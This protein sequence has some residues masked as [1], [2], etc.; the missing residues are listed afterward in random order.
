VRA[1]KSRIQTSLIKST[2][3][4]DTQGSESRAWFLRVAQEKGIEAALA[5]VTSSVKQDKKS[6]RGI[7]DIEI[8][9]VS[10]INNGKEQEDM[11]DKTCYLN[12]FLFVC[13]KFLFL[14]S[15]EKHKNLLQRLFKVST[16]KPCLIWP[17]HRLV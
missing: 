14:F 6:K 2:P 16:Q 12:L 8:H 17:S 9:A 15:L 5:L 11:H 3:V 13:G 4:C 10:I 1:L 7:D